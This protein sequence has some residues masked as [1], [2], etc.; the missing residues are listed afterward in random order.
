MNN[1]LERMELL[2][3]DGKYLQNQACSGIVHGNEHV[4][5]QACSGKQSYLYFRVKCC[6]YLT[7]PG[8]HW[9]R[10]QRKIMMMVREGLKISHVLSKV[11][12]LKNI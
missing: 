3:H 8:V 5:V 11:S 7:V 1:S 12:I 2:I 6:N 10:I 4:H 9:Q